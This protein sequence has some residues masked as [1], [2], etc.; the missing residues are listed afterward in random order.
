MSRSTL[1][2]RLR[3]LVGSGLAGGAPPD[4]V[5]RPLPNGVLDCRIAVNEHGS[6]AVPRSAEHRPA[7]R[8][9]LSGRVW[10]PETVEL[11]RGRDPAGD[12]VHAGAFFGDF[13]P[14]LARSRS[15]GARIYAFEPNTENFRCAQITVLLNGLAD[16]VLTNAAL[17][18]TTGQ[19]ELA[20]TTADG[21]ALGGGSHLVREATDRTV[22]ERVSLTSVDAVVLPERH[23]TVL[24]LDVEGHEAAALA[25]AVRT[26][27]RCRP[28][29]VLE[30][31]PPPEWFEEH[32]DG[33][34]Y[35]VSGHVCDNTILEPV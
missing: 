17:D 16:V 22:T 18:A 20:I 27:R 33:V 31:P 15:A 1:R 34:T 30:S 10:E 3:L 5:R 35:V 24:Q 29:L 7:A 11:L 25:G 26:I 9:V 12:I 13:L 19:G 2:A 4:E 28:L 8:T 6:Y 21:V 32:L 14:A 23:V